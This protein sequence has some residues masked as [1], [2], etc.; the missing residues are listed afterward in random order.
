MGK[1]TCWNQANGPA[2]ANSHDATK[3]QHRHSCLRWAFG[4]LPAVCTLDHQRCAGMY[5]YRSLASSPMGRKPWLQTG[6]AF[7]FF[8]QA[9][10]DPF[11]LPGSR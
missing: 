2:L 4:G 11:A 6:A 8:R 1:S 5:S 7:F 10:L 9:V 3:L